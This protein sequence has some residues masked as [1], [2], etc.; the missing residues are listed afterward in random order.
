M[1]VNWYIVYAVALGSAFTCSVILTAIVRRFAIRYNYVDNP[2]HRKVH[3]E[4]K[5]LLGGTAIVAS[6]YLVLGVGVSVALTAADFGWP[7]VQ[8]HIVQFLGDEVLL[9]LVGIF[10]GGLIIFV[11]G[12]VDDIK[13]LNP[14]KKL[15]GQVV[16][17]GVLVGCGI[18]LELFIDNVWISSAITMFW[19]I[20]MTNSLN[21][22]DNMD[23]LCGGISVIAAI[24]FFLCALPH[25]E[26]FIC[27]ML[28]VFV[29]SVGG[30]LFHNLNPARIFMGD[31]GAMFCGYILATVAIVTTYYSPQADTTRA[32]VV[33]PLLALGVPIFDTCSTVFIR[34]RKGESIMKGDKRHFSHRLVFLGMTQHQAVEFIFL[35]AAVNGLGAA[36]L[37][38]VDR[39]GAIIILAQAC[40]IF[41]LIVLL[42]NAGI[43]RDGSEL[44]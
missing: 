7:W 1:T 30:F 15:V 29:G 33:A 42:M 14:E 36:L 12:L 4:P 3:V 26:T 6:F 40:G 11:L 22:L 38:Q 34:W 32:V 28:M 27:A 44:P 2:G 19:V 35:V 37:H 21:F 8:D 31:A 23:G 5:P 43:A 16:A 39:M 9:K 18:R 13:V 25:G 10:A 17:A 41:S 24:S 20:M